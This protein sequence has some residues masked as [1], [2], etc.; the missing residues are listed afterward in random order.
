MVVWVDCRNGNEDIFAYNITTGEEFQVTFDNKDQKSPA[1]YENIVVWEDNRN[2]QWDIYGMD[3][4]TLTPSGSNG[5]WWKLLFKEYFYKLLIMG[6]LMVYLAFLGRGIFYDVAFFR[7]KKEMPFKKDMSFKYEKIP[8]TVTILLQIGL[9]NAL[10]IMY[11][12]MSTFNR[13][14][15]LLA[16]GMIAVEIFFLVYI[17]WRI[18]C[19]YIYVGDDYLLKFPKSPGK[20]KKIELKSIGK[21]QF[22][23]KIFELQLKDGT[24]EAI[25]VL[26]VHK[27]DE[28]RFIKIMKEFFRIES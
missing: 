28:I 12:F 10:I 20:W 18:F 26:K 15:L 14:C 11:F 1:I 19:P 25:D 3:I 22:R 8:S 6:S 2:G 9:I 13:I 16:V 27:D 17:T 23:I 21:S 5:S 24:T 4:S 7:L